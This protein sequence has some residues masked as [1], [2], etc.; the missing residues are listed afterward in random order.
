MRISTHLFYSQ[1]TRAMADNQA[2][3]SKTQQQLASGRSLSNASDDPAAA[4]RL[5]EV[6]K[7]LAAANQYG[8]NIELATGR[9]A[10]EETSLE[11]A[12]NALQRM[13]ELA[14]QANNAHLSDA[15]RGS[16][17]QEVRQLT[18]HLL[19]IANTQ[20][21]HGEYLFGGYQSQTQ[22]FV[23]NNGVVEYQGDDG[24]REVRVGPNLQM[25]VGD[26]GSEVFGQAAGGLGIFHTLETLAAALETPL[27]GDQAAAS[28]FHQDMDRLLEEVDGGIDQLLTVRS[29][30]GARLNS[31]ESQAQV[32]QVFAER[33]EIAVG[34]LSGLDYAQAMTR[35]SEQMLVLQAAQQSF[36]KVQGLSLFDY[37]R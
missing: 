2:A 27:S 32:N 11:G 19:D 29:R 5:V 14:L 17:A 15:D 30:L 10:L 31:L 4:A 28:Q 24:R 37:L 23:A 26:P 13:R 6:R 18:G 25:T 20:D 9:L 33:M 1:N 16:I 8:R 3:V 22:P 7:E 21:G 34:E 12:G 36:T 35:L